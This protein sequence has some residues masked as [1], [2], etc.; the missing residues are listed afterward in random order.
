[1]IRSFLAPIEDEN[2]IGDGWMKDIWINPN[3]SWIL[4]IMWIFASASNM[5]YVYKVKY[6]SHTRGTSEASF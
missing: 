4:H 6:I 3:V 5:L 2:L 1:M